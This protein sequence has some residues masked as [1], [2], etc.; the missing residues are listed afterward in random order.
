[1]KQNFQVCVLSIVSAIAILAINQTVNAQSDNFKLG[2]EKNFTNPKFGINMKYPSDWSFVPKNQDFSPG[3]YDYSVM[4]P[5]GVAGLGQFCPT[6]M[7][8][9]DPEVLDCVTKSP[10]DVDITVFKLKDGTTLKDFY[11]TKL[12]DP[13][14]DITGSKK[15][16]IIE[17]NKVKISGLSGIE[18]ISTNTLGG[19]TGKALRELGEETPTSKTITEYV[20][21]GSNGY[22]IAGSTDDKNDF[23]RYLPTFRKMIDSFQIEGAKENPLN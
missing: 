1:M 7:V 16:K 15:G 13:T 8:G 6:S 3:I 4:A 5:P 9:S 11:E 23:D 22:H 17:T 2:E 19:S 20:I 21:N 12:K 14:E 10:V 18:T